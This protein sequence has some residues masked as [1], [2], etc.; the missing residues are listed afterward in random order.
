MSIRKQLSFKDEKSGVSVMVEY[1]LIVGILALV[2]A[3]MI[4]QLNTLMSKLPVSNAMKNQF[5]DVA[6]EITSQITDMMIIAPKNGTVVSKVYMPESVGKHTYSIEIKNNKLTVKSSVWSEKVDLGQS[7]L[8]F[9]TEGTTFSSEITHEIVLNTSIHLMPTAVAIVYPTEALVNENVTF[10]MTNSYGEGTLYYKWYFG[11]GSSYPSSGWKEYDPLNPQSGIIYHSYSSPGNYTVTLEVKDSYGYVSYDK[12]NVN[13]TRSPVAKLYVNKFVV[14]STIAPGSTSTVNIFLYGNGINQTSVNI[15]VIHTIDTSGSMSEFTPLSS[16]TGSISPNPAVVSFNLTSGKS[17]FIFV[18]TSDFET[19]YANYNIY[20]ISIFIKS[21]NGNYVQ[22]SDIWIYDGQLGYGYLIN[23]PQSGT[24]S[25]AIEDA[26]ITSEVANV[27]VFEVKSSF[28]GV[29]SIVKTILSDTVTVNPSYKSY[30]IDVP[31]EATELGIQLIPVQTPA[32]L[33]LW[34]QD[35]TTSSK[36]LAVANSSSAWINVTNPSPGY[37]AYVVPILP[38]NTIENF[39]LNTYIPKIDAAKIAAK[40]FNGFLRK[41]DY[42]GVVGFSTYAYYVVVPPTNDT[43]YVNSSIDTLTAGGYTAMA[44]GI[45]KAIDELQSFNNSKNSPAIDVIILL[46][47]GNANID[48]KGQ[49][50]VRQAIKDVIYEANRAKNLGYIIYTIGYGSDANAT[51][52][53]EIAEI[54]GGKYYFAANAEELKSIYT[55]IAKDVLTKVAEN[56]TITDVIPPDLQVVSASGSAKITPTSNGTKVSWS[57]PAIRINQSWL[58]SITIKT[59]KTGILLTDVV[60]VSNVTYF[61][62]VKSK[63]VTIPLPAR[64]LNVTTIKTA[65]FKLR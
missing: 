7:T 14:P 13:V 62:V 61:D 56:V 20:P 42:V 17:Y 48:L 58:G 35:N 8:G 12:V 45:D 33:Y 23:N 11:D 27:Y 49:Y 60:N 46:T 53:Q 6:S 65:S 40:T 2:M 64:K 54:T 29:Y 32:T 36:L 15:T 1:I 31:K 43:S 3:F 5:Q 4:P 44:S 38:P 34:L 21:P 9:V 16:N 19:F 39:Y 57:I 30:G 26:K 51:L 28:F 10:D 59:S 63:V 50:N 41:F 37:T 55:S 52:L 24:W 18:T 22:A 47:D 25:L